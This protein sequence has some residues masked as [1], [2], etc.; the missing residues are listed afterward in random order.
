MLLDLEFPLLIDSIVMCD[1][2]WLHHLLTA[3]PALPI[4]VIDWIPPVIRKEPTLIQATPR[5]S[6]ARLPPLQFSLPHLFPHL[7]PMGT[8]YSTSTVGFGALYSTHPATLCF[9]CHSGLPVELP[10]KKTMPTGFQIICA[11]LIIL[12]KIVRKLL[13]P[14][15]A[16]NSWLTN[17]LNLRNTSTQKIQLSEKIMLYAALYFYTF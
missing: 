5:S 17:G 2:T 6:L 1:V 3:I 8:L 7:C 10:C 9:A 14:L 11:I 13:R 15:E 16:S 12:W 4:A